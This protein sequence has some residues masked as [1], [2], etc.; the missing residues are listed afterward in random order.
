VV[1]VTHQVTI[2]ALTGEFAPSGGGVVFELD[3]SG[4]PRVLGEF[5]AD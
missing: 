3:G 1:L 4:A 2:T 5:R